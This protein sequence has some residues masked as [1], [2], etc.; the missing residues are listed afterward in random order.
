MLEAEPDNLR[1]QVRLAELY[2]SMNQQKDALEMFLGAAQRV[3]DRGDHAESLHLAERVL[4]LDRENKSA[5]LMK[6]R[7]L[8]ASGKNAEAVGLLEPLS[9]Q[10]SEGE[11]AKLLF[12]Q[13]LANR[14]NDKAAVLADKMF[15][16]NPKNFAPAHQAASALL[17]AGDLNR[18]QDSALA[19]TPA[20]DR[21]GRA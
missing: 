13:Y 16:A 11:T 9:K 3:L 7:A 15:A 5:L 10:D 8:S 4:Q 6:V 12:E 1:V 17:D 14:Q 18:A 20:Y 21:R 19:D 2:L